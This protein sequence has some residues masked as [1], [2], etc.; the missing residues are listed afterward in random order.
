MIGSTPFP[1]HIT[2]GLFINIRHVKKY[3]GMWKDLVQTECLYQ[4]GEPVSPHIA[5]K[6]AH[7]NSQ[8]EVE[9]CLYISVAFLCSPHLDASRP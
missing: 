8:T 7:E 4:F 6:L 1:Q 5:A 9:P 3:S 2:L